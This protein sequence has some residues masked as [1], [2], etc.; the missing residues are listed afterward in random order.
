MIMISDDLVFDSLLNIYS[1]IIYFLFS[2]KDL[3]KINFR[4]SKMQ[5]DSGYF[6]IQDI[7]ASQERVSCK[8]DI[9]VPNM[10]KNKI[11]FL[12]LF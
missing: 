8:F 2:T 6:N 11:L 5:T 9:E 10:G 4:H 3:D 1:W 12:K 7:L